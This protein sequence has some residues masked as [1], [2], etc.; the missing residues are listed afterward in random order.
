MNDPGVSEDSVCPRGGPCKRVASTRTMCAVVDELIPLYSTDGSD[1]PNSAT[2]AVPSTTRVVEALHALQDALFPGRMSTELKEDIILEAFVMERLARAHGL[3][4]SEIALALPFRWIG[5]FAQLTGKTR[6]ACDVE[7]EAEA[8]L[9]RLFLA[10]P[11]IRGLLVKDVEAAYVGDPAATTFA[12][13][14]LAYPAVKAITTHRIAHELYRADVPLIPRIMSEHAHM[15]TGID[16]HPGA[17]IGES[18]FIDHGTGVVIGETCTIG[19][20][21]K[22]YQGVT[23]GAKSF[24]TDEHGHP[25][26]GIKRHPT[27]EDDVVIYA[28]ATI[29]GG[30][31]VVGRG[32]EIGGNVWLAK[33]VPPG[34]KVVQRNFEIEIRNAT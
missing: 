27:I 13:V 10:L 25:I 33:S 29:L 26:K 24:P 14:M 3:L 1:L 5:H 11:R 17:T 31:T 20:R 4:R 28:G 22:L 15:H 23:L 16:I 30:D 18:F 7:A 19:N 2:G 12:E 21:V 8:V 6:A 9:D 34:S 32:S